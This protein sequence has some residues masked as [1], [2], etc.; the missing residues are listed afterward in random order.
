MHIVCDPNFI[1]FYCIPP[2]VTALISISPF[3]TIHQ[4]EEAKEEEEELEHDID[5]NMA[6]LQTA[7]AVSLKFHLH[8]HHQPH[9]LPSLISTAE[10]SR[11]TEELL[12][13]RAPPKP[14]TL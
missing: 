9:P 11:A 14:P 5:L 2:L 10:E 4:M 6:H 1:I 13:P 7:M 3:L 8:H 12:S